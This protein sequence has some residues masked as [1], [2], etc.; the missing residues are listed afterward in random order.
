M[1]TLANYVNLNTNKTIGVLTVASIV[2]AAVA[3]FTNKIPGPAVST[4]AVACVVAVLLLLSNL[5]SSWRRD[6]LDFQHS[7]RSEVYVLEILASRMV[8]LSI[9]TLLVG[10]SLLILLTGLLLQ[11][12]EIPPSWIDTGRRAVESTRSVIAP[13]R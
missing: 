3:V 1:Q 8:R 10:F 7:P 6:N 12:M 9:A 2:F 11:T 13:S 5:W 4:A